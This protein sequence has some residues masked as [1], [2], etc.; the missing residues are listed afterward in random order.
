MIEY[1][2]LVNLALGLTA[3]GSLLFRTSIRNSELPYEVSLLHYMAILLLFGL[4]TVSAQQAREQQ[5]G[6][7][8]VVVTMVK[9]S[10]LV[11]LWRTR[12]TLYRTGTRHQGEGT[13]GDEDNPNRKIQA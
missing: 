8:V 12:K 5:E 3:L 10:T 9:I 2:P 1:L 6:V 7:D 13:N 4:L 11:I